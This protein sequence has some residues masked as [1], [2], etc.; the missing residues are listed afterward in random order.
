[1]ARLIANIT[2]A[3]IAATT[4][5][6]S[7]SHIIPGTLYP[8]VAGKLL[9]GATSHGATY[10]VAQSD[11]HS[12]Y[13]TDIKGSKPIKD[14]RIGAHFGSQRHMGHSIQLLEQETASH[15][16]DVYSVDGREWLRMVKGS[17]ALAMQNNSSGN[18]PYIGTSTSGFVEITGYWIDINVKLY[19]YPSARGFTTKIDGGSISSENTSF[20]PSVSSP[21][22]GRFVDFSSLGNLGL[23][24]TLGIHTLKLSPH[25]SADYIHLYGIELITQDTT[26]TASK[27]KIQI[28]P[29]TVIS[30]GRKSSI[31]ATAHHYNPFAFAGDGTTAVAIGN[32][33]SHGKVATGWAGSTSAYFDSTLDTATSLGLAAW[34]TGGNY[35]RPVNGGRVVKWV[36]STGV[37]KTSVNMMPPT[38][39]SIGVGS[40]A[41]LPTSHAWTTVYQPKF[42]STTIDHSLAEV[43]KTFHWREFGNGNANG[44]ATGTYKDASM[45]DSTSRD[46]AYVMDDGLTSFSGDGVK[47]NGGP[48]LPNA[49]NDHYFITFIGTGIG[50]IE[51]VTQNKSAT[52]AQN[53]PYGTHILKVLRDADTTPDLTIDG[54]AINDV[55]APLPTTGEINQ[56]TFHQPKMPPIPE[57]AVVISDYMLM[58]D[59]VPQTAG[60]IEKTSKGVRLQSCSRD[61]FFDAGGAF[62]FQQGQP[63]QNTG[64]KFY[65]ANGTAQT[66]LPF[67]GTGIVHRHESNTGDGVT[68][69]FTNDG[70]NFSGGTFF[71]EASTNQLVQTGASSQGRFGGIHSLTLGTYTPKFLATGQSGKN[72]RGAAYEIATP[73]HTSSHYQ[74]FETPYLHELVGGDR[75]ME[76]N[77]LVVSPD[78]KTWDQVTRNT[79]Y[80]GPSASLRGSR[81]GGDIAAG[82]YYV[83]DYWRGSGSVGAGAN[84]HNK[85]FAIAYDQVL[86]LEDGFYEA[87]F[88]MQAA[89]A[90]AAANEANIRINRS[91]ML[92]QINSSGVG[93][94]ANRIHGITTMHLKRG[95][96]VSLYMTDG[97]TEG[98]S[99]ELS[100]FTMQKLR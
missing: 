28:P 91:G 24:Q 41:A 61:V 47:N 3:N 55:S 16:S 35:Y 36:D 44:G 94:R 45:L 99:D 54:V 38:G 39:T 46:I 51:D 80:M 26:D 20:Q 66:K 68:L 34:V 96:S 60:G 52:I 86:C 11:G 97:S 1:M 71:G 59:F 93:S 29:Q 40:D 76:Q 73:I 15:G 13:Y 79:S 74:T 19:P 87:E 64:F 70:T 88:S 23:N 67:F 2:D 10:G 50:Y 9:D 81:D 100:S 56:I 31:A 18:E 82:A 25:S 75:N 7:R 4:G 57:D 30:Q 58:A 6:L 89:A 17:G 42:S 32:T 48:L 72:Y 43:A 12:Y 14:P 98:S 85:G 63:L 65:N 83:F 33:T 84:Y 21:L 53:L 22:G 37:I 92:I 5:E 62:T 69:G 95:D 90:D 8:A 27:S 78:G 49:T 77:N